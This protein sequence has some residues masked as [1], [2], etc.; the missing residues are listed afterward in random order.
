MSGKT[1]VIQ[2]RTTQTVSPKRLLVFVV[3]VLAVSAAIV[4]GS[5]ASNESAAVT[6]AVDLRV[7][8]AFRHPG[9]GFLVPASGAEQT[10]DY[11]SRYLTRQTGISDPGELHR[12]PDYGIRHM[13]DWRALEFVTSED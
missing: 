2:P 5:M 1:I 9:E 13:A 11:L 10:P 6:D 7:D 8:Y 4:F 12:S 3:S